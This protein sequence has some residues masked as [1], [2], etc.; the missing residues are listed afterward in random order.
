MSK[1]RSSNHFM[2]LT[3]PRETYRSYCK[4][5]ELSH[6]PPTPGRGALLSIMHVYNQALLEKYID[7]TQVVQASQETKNGIKDFI[8]TLLIER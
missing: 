4:G 6:S 8:D 5:G 7:L 1:S 2:R 3:W